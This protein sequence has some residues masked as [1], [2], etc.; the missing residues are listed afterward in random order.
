[1]LAGGLGTRLRSVV[2]DRPKP[3]APVGGRAF[4]EILLDELAR[5][6]CSRVV[7]S[8][9]YRHEL[10]QEAIGPIH[11]GMQI[12]YSIETHALGTGGA[13]WQAVS[14]CGESD[15]LV[16]NG[17]SFVR[18]DLAGMMA[19]HVRAAEMIT[20]CTVHVSDA[21]RYG[22]VLVQGGR[23]VGFAEKGAHGPAEINAGV[24]VIRRSVVSRWS[25]PAVFSFEREFLARHV[26]ELAPLAYPAEGGFIDIGVPEDFERAQHM[27]A[28]GGRSP[29]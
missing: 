4:L 6:G 8:V 1:M 10:I 11:A 26:L 2:A 22:A 20:I 19:A 3:L 7:L 29:W 17:D 12:M 14:S 28:R 9:G 16:L 5:Q 25:M 23:V 24:Y 27:F 13:I 15:F 18:V 21:G